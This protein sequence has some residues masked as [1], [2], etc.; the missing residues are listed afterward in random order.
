MRSRRT[1]IRNAALAVPTIRT[2]WPQRKS[3]VRDPRIQH[4]VVLM[5]ENRSFDHM[6]GYTFR[7]KKD[8]VEGLPADLST[9]PPNIDPGSHKAVLPSEEARYSGDFFP[10]PGH[11]FDD[12]MLQMFQKKHPGADDDP[13]MEGFV[14]SYLETCQAAGER[15]QTPAEQS[16]KIMNCYSERMLPVLS[17]LAKEYA[18]CDRWFCSVPGPTLPNR[19][20]VHAGTS[21]GQLDLSVIEFN[22]EPT[23]YEVLDGD[24]VSSAIY[25]SG[26]TAA[27]TF[28]GL[29]KYQDRFFATIDDFY[30]DCAENR[31]PAYSFL[32]PRYGS[33]LTNGVFRPQNDQHPDS[34]VRSGEELIYSVYQA[35]RGNMKVW[36]ST[37]LVIIYDEHGGLF[38][39]VSP[40]K[41]VSPDDKTD[42]VIDWF[43]FDR[44]G[45]RVPAV[46]V[47]AFT[48]RNTVLHDTFDHTSVIA[49]A[50]LL[51]TG[52]C[53]DPI[54]HRR[55]QCANTFEGVLNR[56]SPRKAV[57]ADFR[58]IRHPEMR[59]RPANHLQLKWKEFAK[60][61]NS[62]LPRSQR[63]PIDPD[64]LHTDQDI[65]H[66][67]E[68]VYAGVRGVR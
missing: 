11:D 21:E 63:T 30:E 52:K 53:N 8:G 12:V 56:E 34:D 20:F 48:E 25:A 62:K 10:D 38:D 37:M 26:W 44:L 50:R 22:V 57:D 33:G 23:I 59:K 29:I 45:P 36:N 4:I 17:T 68:S 32:E 2:M 5:L 7:G 24:N 51:L 18:V 54:L 14:A 28:E 40:C 27:A 15:S 47:S 49:T 31:L 61:V 19:K 16:H 43:R 35:I 60:H 58:P 1:F 39:H 64:S 55:A 13:N 41:T 67:L 9:V 42:K 65:Q 46:I 3:C 66:F 6:L